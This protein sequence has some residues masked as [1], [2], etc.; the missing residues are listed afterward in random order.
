MLSSMCWV[1]QSLPPMT[2]LRYGK[3]VKRWGVGT[4]FLWRKGEG[5]L[6]ADADTNGRSWP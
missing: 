2:M 4:I 1:P 5:L 3:A 6:V